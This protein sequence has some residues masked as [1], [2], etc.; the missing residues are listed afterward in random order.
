MIHGALSREEGKS[1]GNREGTEE[2]CISSPNWEGNCT[3]P[4]VVHIYMHR[5]LGVSCYNVPF[6]KFRQMVKRE[7]IQ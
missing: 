6:L 5:T 4:K 2:A 1:E 3:L 7:I